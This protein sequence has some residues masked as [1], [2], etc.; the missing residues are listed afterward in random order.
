MGFRKG[1]STVDALF[2]LRQIIE[3]R[4]EYNQETHIAFVDLEKAFD[5]VDRQKLWNIMDRRGYPQHLI[6]SVKILYKS[7]SV[8]LDLNGRLSGDI[9]INKG[10]RQGCCVSPTLFNIY[11]D[12]M[13]R[14]WKSRVTSGIQLNKS[15]CMGSLL[16]ADDIVL[17]QENE[18]DLQR[19][20]FQLQEVAREYSLTISVRKTK[21]MA[22]KG[23]YPVRTKIVINNSTLE[24]V[25]RFKYLGCAVSYESEYDISCLLY[26]SRC[27]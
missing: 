10:V 23:K 13:L 26:T 15:I 8:V 14:A 4:R 25:S 17:I 6:N 20:M 18:D 7:T 2:V 12:D 5:N 21:T 16:Y 27:V 11:I 9:P 3:K 19:A 1:R 22:F 24:Q